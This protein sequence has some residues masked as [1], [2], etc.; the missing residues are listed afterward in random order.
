MRHHKC[1]RTFHQE[2]KYRDYDIF[3][4]NDGEWCVQPDCYSVLVRCKTKRECK[5]WIDRHLNSVIGE[6]IS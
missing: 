6:N 4:N 5:D 2:Y 1:E 3:K